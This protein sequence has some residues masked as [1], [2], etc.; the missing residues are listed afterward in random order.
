MSLCLH[1]ADQMLV[2][3][4]EIVDK[5]FDIVN[6]DRAALGRVGGAI[7]KR[8]GDRGFKGELR[9]TLLGCDSPT[10][11]NHHPTMQNNVAMHHTRKHLRSAWPS[12]QHLP[13]IHA[14]QSCYLLCYV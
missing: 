9:L 11:Y 4:Q 2:F 7:A 10:P 5:S 3:M 8:Y 6:T 1:Y 12:C 14:S 13:R